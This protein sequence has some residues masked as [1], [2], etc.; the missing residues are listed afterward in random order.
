M[1]NKKL[2]IIINQYIP[3]LIEQNILSQDDID[4]LANWLKSDDYINVNRNNKPVFFMDWLISAANNDERSLSFI[5]FFNDTLNKLLE[6]SNGAFDQKLEQKIRNIVKCNVDHPSYLDNLS[7][8]LLQS[9]LIEKSSSD[10]YKFLG[11]EF[12]IGNGKH[13]DFAFEK[14]DKIM[15]IELTN[16]HYQKNKNLKKLL[17]DRFKKKLKDKTKDINEAQIYLSE[18]YQ[19][20][21]IH[22]AIAIFVWEDTFK[23]KGRPVEIQK[24]MDKYK[25]TL[26]PPITLLCQIDTDGNFDWDICP[27]TEALIRCNQV[28]QK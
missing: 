13:A 7:E 15:L 1:D 11:M 16:I 10:G 17:D 18:K 8:L 12:D 28:K 6:D 27:L 22:L 4:G 2:N 25:D 14:D 26:L 21:E 23:I 9:Y 3:C 19:K 20:K 5:H 24:V